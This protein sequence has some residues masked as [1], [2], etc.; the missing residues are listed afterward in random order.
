MSPAQSPVSAPT[1][2][3]VLAFNPACP[4]IDPDNSVLLPLGK[5][6]KYIDDALLGLGLHTEARTSFI[7]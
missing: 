6:T 7:T 4:I 2:L 1:E 3:P 5:V